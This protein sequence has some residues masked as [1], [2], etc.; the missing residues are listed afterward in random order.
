M[1]ILCF[2]PCTRCRRRLREKYRNLKSK[3]KRSNWIPSHWQVPDALET[4][5]EHQK[6]SDLSI[7]RSGN[8]DSLFLR[9]LPLEIR[10]RIYGIVFSDPALLLEHQDTAP[11][12]GESLKAIN[13]HP[14]NC[15]WRIPGR[16]VAKSPYPDRCV[17]DLTHRFPPLHQE[18]RNS[19]V[20]KYNPSFIQAPPLA[21]KNT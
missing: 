8:P 13:H 5:A 20:P 21:S 16:L 19:L 6:L 1:A 15:L 10:L 2:V 18:G 11:S 9:M 14:I 4:R 7:D 12:E 17:G 3:V